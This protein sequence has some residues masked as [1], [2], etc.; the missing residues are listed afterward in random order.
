MKKT[1]VYRVLLQGTQT[2]IKSKDIYWDKG[3]CITNIDLYNRGIVTD[4]K[5]AT[6]SLK[7]EML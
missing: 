1:L 5:V 3:K 4:D 6:S 2:D 7:N